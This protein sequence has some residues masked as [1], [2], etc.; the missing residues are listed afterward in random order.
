[1]TEQ[2]RRSEA[3]VAYKRKVND[4]WRNANPKRRAK[5]LPFPEALDLNVFEAPPKYDAAAEAL[6]QA[7]VRDFH[8][9]SR[10]DAYRAA[11][12]RVVR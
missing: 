10:N 11:R 6:L 1:M 9:E 3:T 7:A 4:L 8:D 12:A 5:H 2:E